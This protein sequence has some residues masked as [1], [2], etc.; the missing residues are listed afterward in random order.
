MI[1]AHSDWERQRERLS[2]YL[3]GELAAVERV[4][5]EAHLRGCDQCQRELSALR[6]T[7]GLLRALPVPTPPRSFT[8]PARAMPARRAAPPAW[9]RPA[10]FIGGIAA[11]VGLGVL[12]STSLPGI[13]PMPMRG[14]AG[15]SSSV[16]APPNGG[17]STLYTPIA[18]TATTS[19]HEPQHAVVVTPAQEQPFPIAPV[20][21]GTLLV[22]G[23]A[24]LTLGSLARRRDRRAA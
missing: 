4:D 5:L 3:D 12:I 14:A 22:G 10:Q 19:A 13:S 21:G 7:R 1:V 8:L 6:Q 15:S 23:A 9:A 11:M 18:P 20:T 17:A 24:A 16:S 2:A